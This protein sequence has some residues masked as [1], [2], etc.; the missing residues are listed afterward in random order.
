MGQYK[1]HVFVCTGGKTCPLDGSA[2]VHSIFK[3][4]AAAAGLKGQVRIN[5]AGCMNQCG[6]GPMV[7]IYPDDVWYSRVDE[8]GAR[9]ILQEHII[10]GTVVEDYRYIA[11]PGDNKLV[12]GDP[13]P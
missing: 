10:E 3:K 1:R 7:V 12:E 2:A 11:P 5:H 4:G 9:R 13:N 8:N 6:H